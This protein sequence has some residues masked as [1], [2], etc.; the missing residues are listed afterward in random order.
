[1]TSTASTTESRPTSTKLPLSPK[2]QFL[3]AYQREHGTTM[4][5][6]KAFP[7]DQQDFKPHP[8]SNSALQLAWTF[9]IEQMLC[10]EALKGPLNFGAGFPKSPPT[11]AE[12]IAAF[13][14]NYKKVLQQVENAS[15]EDLAQ[16]VAFPTGP[17]QMGEQPRIGLLWFMLMDQIHHRGQL[18]VYLRMVGGKVPSIYG[19]SKD[20]PWR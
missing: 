2:K 3:D 19:P 9:A 15:D 5:I 1:M 18:S 7:A 11:M 20:E 17:G 6:L 4:K 10:S 8:T 13:E 14:A 16:P 12:A